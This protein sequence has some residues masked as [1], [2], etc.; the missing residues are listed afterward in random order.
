MRLL[1]SVRCLFCAFLLA[2]A[3]TVHAQ[4]QR[5]PNTT[6]AMPATPPTFGYT[7]SNTFPGLSFTNPVCIVSPP[8][9]T[10]RLFIVGKNGFIYVITNLA[11]P[12]E[13]FFLNISNRVTSTG[14]N[15][16]D[17]GEQGL[18]SLAFDPGYVTNNY[19]YVFYTGQATNGSGS[20]QLHHFLSRF[21]FMAGNTNLGDPNSETVLYV[22]YKRAQNHNGG[23][24]VF[25]P[26]DYLYVS[27]GDE[28]NEHDTFTNAQH[29]TW[30]LWSGIL[31]L[32]VDKIDP[33]GLPPNT[34]SDLTQI[35]S[36]T[37][38]YFIPHDN[39]FVGA[40]TFDGQAINANDVQTEFWAVGLRNPWRMFFDPVTS[41]LFCADVGD[42]KFEE[43]DVITKGGN[44]G[45]SWYEG[46]S[47]PP[48]GVT[49]T[50]LNATPTPVNPIAPF[51][52]Y[53]HGSAT[54]QGNA[55]IG[56]PVYR[57]SNLSQLYGYYIFGD[58]VDGNIWAIPATQALSLTSSNGTITP[59]VPLFTDAG[60]G[61]SAFGVDPRNGDILY[62]SMNGN[63]IKRI[64]YNSSTSGAPL[65]PTLADTGAFT[66]LMSLT[67]PQDPLQPAAGI[68]PYTINVPFW[69][70][71]AIKSRWVSV[72]N[73]NLTIGFNSNGNWSFPTGTVWIKHF[74]LELTNGDS[75]S[76]IRLETRLLV[77]NSSGIYGVTYRWNGSHT[78]ATLVPASGLDDAF[79]I[80]NGGILYT[81]D[82]HYPSQTECQTCHTPA[83]GYGLGFRTEQLNCP[84][85]YGAGP[86]NQIQA[87][88]AAGYFSSPVTNDPGTLLA[89]AAATNTSAS[90]EF[91]SRSFLAANCSQC[92]QPGGTAQQSQWDARIT[93]PTAFAGLINGAL[94]NN[95]GST[96]NYV[97]APLQL[98]NSILFVRDSIR[99]LGAN[100]SLQMPPLD[101]NLTDTQA[102]NLIAS[103]ILS[104]TNTFWLGAL[105]D[106]QTVVP[107]NSA[108]YGV[109]FLATSDYMNG[110]TLSVSG[111]P[112]NTTA[113]FSPSVVNNTT[114]NSTITITTAGN[115]PLGSYLLTITG[116]DGTLTSTDTMTL[117]ISSNNAAPGTL[118]WTGTSGTDTNWSTPLNWTNLTAGG[119][120]PPG[121]SNNVIFYNGGAGPTNF[122]DI[123]INMNTLWYCLLPASGGVITQF[124][125]INP[126]QTINVAGTNVITG[127][128]FVTAPYTL[129]V[130]TNNSANGNSST[131]SAVIS[132]SG[133]TLNVNRPDGVMAVAQFNTSGNHPAS[134]STHAVLDLSGLDCFFANVSQL[135]IG[136]MANGSA[137]TIYLAKTNNITVVNG[138][139]TGSAGLDIGNNASN[140]G[141]P[142]FLYLGQTNRINV[143]A[144]RAGGAKGFVGTIAFNPAVI[145]QNPSAWFRG[146]GGDTSRVS[147][148][149]ISDLVS[150]TGTANVTNPKGTNDF[151]NGTINALID[152]LVLG[153]TTSTAIGG[154]ISS[155][156]VSQ[157]TLTF[158]AGTIDVNN[159]TN[160][161]QL[162]NPGGT[163]AAGDS[164]DTGIGIINVNG[165]TLRVNNNLV[166]GAGVSALSVPTSPNGVL[167][168]ADA[169]GTLNVNGGT[170]IASKIVAGNFGLAFINLN[171]GT[172]VVSN[173]AGAPANAIATVT[174]ASSTLH[175][176]LNGSTVVTNLV[177]TNLIASG[178]NA[179]TIDSIASL[180][181]VTTF[182][183]ISY[184]G[185]AP[186]NGTFV[187][188]TLPAGFSASLVNNTA[189]KR[190]DLVVAPNST[191]TPNVTAVNF[192]GTNLIIGG[193]HGFP[194]ANYYVLA[195]T[196]LSLPRNQWLPIS[197][198]PFDVNGGFNF[199][200][201]MNPGSLQMYYLLQLQQ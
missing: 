130:G 49:T 88:S 111:L 92:H 60:A 103:W 148:W 128:S 30:R 160:G 42:D 58:Y 147:T 87:L 186:A 35:Y 67:S 138:S 109:T 191:V 112:A 187:K 16:G 126:G 193:S 3:F 73:T 104:L 133:G 117:I 192:F 94:V 44:Y 82:W 155:N 85:D 177:T 182:P 5:V 172:L 123:N 14:A 53:A 20:T 125:R 146:T 62:T 83:G 70:D 174:V 63:S 12:T 1:V 4:L 13:S 197:T 181:N 24:I 194:N 57:G 179:I 34:N 23:D 76:Q 38:N 113:G 162:A 165:G 145:G 139:P 99:D 32:D 25:G 198:N 143:N 18:L 180:G 140:A 120:G 93:T 29:I 183:I 119:N 168:T 196:N 137:G 19:F 141:D 77:K 91:R 100:P 65:P 17:A 56:G 107:G 79:V 159:L 116:T 66:N 45:W 75:A 167:T 131:I 156:R 144:L 11:A 184:A 199:T 169:Q 185:T 33:L 142:S 86:T 122:A 74:N 40:S 129:L 61:I 157:G 31:R 68:V 171:N 2:F 52:A 151:S 27:V 158:N 101:S 134:A 154:T 59:P 69:S 90:L 81:Q 152:S 50:I 39:P 6:L 46:T 28:G 132:G 97:I 10:N 55:I 127:S 153:K 110:V 22:Q 36:K 89:L 43:A 195:S 200:N 8:G 78:N 178:V 80:N 37:T 7:S 114:T 21:K 173:T 9:E 124:T 26:D 64:T 41:N 48:S 98:T 166:L 149:I 175:F 170:V 54:N 115:T 150:A 201:P 105:P 136:C 189:Q 71:N 118:V 190:I 176:Q 164:S 121:I 102:T 84:M 106:P 108:V 72:P 135:L 188:G 47:T 15:S 161:W 96:S 95:L 51:V 163:I